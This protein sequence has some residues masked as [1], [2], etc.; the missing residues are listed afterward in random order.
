MC[1]CVWGGRG[2]WS[3]GCNVCMWRVCNMGR[4][5]LKCEGMGEKREVIPVMCVCVCV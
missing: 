3:G 2:C 1:V 5:I 4:D